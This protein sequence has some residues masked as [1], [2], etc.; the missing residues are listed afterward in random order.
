M[1]HLIDPGSWYDAKQYFKENS[2]LGLCLDTNWFSKYW[3]KER[4]KKW[5]QKHAIN[6]LKTT[7]YVDWEV[8]DNFLFWGQ[9]NI[10]DFTKIRIAFCQYMI[11]HC[12]EN[13]YTKWEQFAITVKSW[14]K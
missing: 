4:D 6:F 5:I 10:D 1:N 11:E 2:S 8:E 3:E 13:P 14:F 7:N 9:R 12:T